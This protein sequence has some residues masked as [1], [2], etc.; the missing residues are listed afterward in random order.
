MT[1]FWKTEFKNMHKINVFGDENKLKS[2]RLAP[3]KNEEHLSKIHLVH[4]NS[5]LIPNS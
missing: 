1:F 2:V 5:N 3:E 4:L